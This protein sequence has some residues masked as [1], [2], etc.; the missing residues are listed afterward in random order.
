MKSSSIFVVCTIV[1][2][3][4]TC[5]VSSQEP[6]SFKIASRIVLVD[7]VVKDRK[8]NFVPTLSERDFEILE[9]GVPQRIASF[10]LNGR[11]KPEI[12]NPTTSLEADTSSNAATARPVSI[13]LLDLLNTEPKDRPYARSA[14]LRYIE[15]HL[16]LGQQVAVFVLADKLML[17]QDF[18][19]DAA[20]LKLAIER[21]RSN[22]ADPKIRDRDADDLERIAAMTNDG[23]L[24]RMVEVLRRFEANLVLEKTTNRVETTMHALR[25]ITYAAGA[26]PG[27]KSLVWVSGAF[28]LTLMSQL[29]PNARMKELNSFEGPMRETANLLNS[30]QIAVYPVDVRGMLSLSLIPIEETHS[31]LWVRDQ[32]RFQERTNRIPEEIQGPQ[33]AMK[34]LAS[35]TGGVAFYNRND[36]ENAINQAVE[37]NSQSYTIAYYPSNRKYDGSFRKITVKSKV[38]GA[39]LRHRRGYFALDRTYVARSSTPRDLLNA[40]E[41]D[42]GP[43]T[44]LQLVARLEPEAPSAESS[45]HVRLFVRGSGVEFWESG[46]RMTAALDFAAIALDPAGKVAGSTFQ[47]GETNLSPLERDQARQSGMLYTLE[48]KLPKGRFVV[49]A[50]VRDRSSGRI[51]SAEIPVTV[52]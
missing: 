4:A 17:L 37:D 49:R 30:A 48:L 11:V 40:L 36:L 46:Q 8:G 6:A 43:Y 51:G 12:V 34:E 21:D 3:T 7:V 2:F 45:F 41:H 15:Q 27:R 9:D 42:V 32:R 47:Q 5:E 14:M 13:L 26:K 52:E 33:E 20:R 10:S 44:Q 19:G 35:M 22:A 23:I 25:S 31:G 39:Q 38:P 28:P 18:T 29:G 16:Q 24:M 50:G 1:L